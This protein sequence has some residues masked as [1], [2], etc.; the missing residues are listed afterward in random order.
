MDTTEKIA[1]VFGQEELLYLLRTLGLPDL[2]GMGEKPW[3]EITRETSV[4]VLDAVGRSL[5]ARGIV[6]FDG[7]GE[8]VIEKTVH[9]ILTASVY[10]RQIVLLTYAGQDD[11]VHQINYYRVP[12]FDVCQ[13]VIMPWLY[14][15]ELQMRTDLGQQDVQGWTAPVKGNF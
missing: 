5:F 1:I 11:Q 4:L 9:A 2:P 3:G 14:Q 7:K 12:E 8:I 10:A 13:R 6:S 15:F